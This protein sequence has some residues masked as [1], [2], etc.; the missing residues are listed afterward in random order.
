MKRVVH[1]FVILGEGGLKLF[2]TPVLVLTWMYSIMRWKKDG[3]NLV[4]Y[5]DN[6][7][8]SYMKQLQLDILYDE[9]IIEQTESWKKE[10][11]IN[12]YR[13]WA[14]IKLLS[15]YDQ[16]VK[17]PKDEIVVA[18]LDLFLTQPF[19]NFSSIADVV[20]AA[21]IEKWN[22]YPTIKRY[23]LPDGYSLPEWYSG[24]VLPY[25]TG[26][27]YFKDNSHAEK[28]VSEILKM[29]RHNYNLGESDMAYPMCNFEQRTIAEYCNYNKLQIKCIFPHHTKDC[30]EQFLYYHSNGLHWMGYKKEVSGF[31]KES[32]VI[33]L[34]KMIRHFDEEYY[35]KIKDNILWK[36]EYQF[37]KE[38]LTTI[39]PDIPEW[40][41]IENLLGDK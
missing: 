1:S 12:W 30:G 41:H 35:N 8:Y 21:D 5:V 29:V 9:I 6:I 31:R 23:P 26:V 39:L 3:Y 14:S 40:C 7:G 17:H 34:L 38:D 4:M 13:A 36:D 25:N 10:E 2:N 37:M 19:Q 11:D 20:L 18:D 15:Y 27:I 22:I 24:D 28:V 16:L 32:Y 33:G